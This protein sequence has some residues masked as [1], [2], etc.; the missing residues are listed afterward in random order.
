MRAQIGYV[1]K[2][3]V[4]VMPNGSKATVIKHYIGCVLVEYLL[5]GGRETFDNEVWV[6]V[7]N[8]K[9]LDLTRKL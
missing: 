7:Q 9:C 2:A 6:D 4:V 3:E 8:E 1:K 5:N